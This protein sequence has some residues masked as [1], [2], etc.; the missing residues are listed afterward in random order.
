MGA[1][2]EDN[3]ELTLKA[4]TQDSLTRK[5]RFYE[6]GAVGKVYNYFAKSDQEKPLDKFDLT[7]IGGPFYNKTA[8][9]GVALVGSGL[10]HLQ[11]SNPSL[12]RSSISLIG[13]ASLKGMFSLS[14]K[15]LNFF[16]DDKYRA[17]YVLKVETFKTEFWGLGYEAGNNDD[18]S[19]FFR[20]NRLLFEGDF[21]FRLAQNTYLGPTLYYHYYGADKRDS[22]VN[23]LLVDDQGRSLD[24]RS[25]TQAVGFSLLYDSRDVATCPTKGYYVNLQQ[26]VAP[27]FLGNKRTFA[28]TELFVRAY[29]PVWKGGVLAGEVH[30]L[31]N[32][33]GVPW[34]EMA[35]MGTDS[36]M[37]G[38]Y[39]GRFNDRNLVE[40]QI[41]LRQQ[42][43]KRIGV[44]AW[45]GCANVFDKPSKAQLR[46]TLYNYGIGAR[47]RFKPGVN[48]RLDLG[49]TTKGMGFVINM[50]EAF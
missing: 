43:W 5:V 46:H 26:R 6:K 28:T 44:V 49:M 38:Y 13:Q 41:E 39:E 25:S 24:K 19:S 16:P 31:L 14:L 23:V 4:D 12:Q 40:G 3:V 30:S 11:P 1:Q 47:W 7:F 8:N 18:N 36:R 15:G 10:Y 29:A 37:R 33:G 42:V 48:I 35:R 20:R 21:M 17:S 9:F 50:N 2:A 45:V 34:M 32:V 22:L 27:S